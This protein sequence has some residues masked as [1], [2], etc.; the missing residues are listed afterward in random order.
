[1]DLEPKKNA[2]IR[3][4]KAA[5]WYTISNFISKCMLYLFTPL[6]TRV[7]T[8]VQYGQ[9]NNYLSWQS[10]L[11][12]LLA[13]DMA[14]TVAVAYVDHKD[15]KTFHCYISTVTFL[16]LTIPAA[17]GAAMLIFYRQF[18][19]LLGM[20]PIYLVLM[21]INICTTSA[22]QIFQAEQRSK[23]QYKLS[24]ALTLGNSFGNML[25]TLLLV[26]LLPNKLF[27]VVLGSIAV[28]TVINVAICVY[29]F[30][31]DFSIKT[32]YI[33][34]A[35]R[36][37]LPL[38]PHVVSASLLSS[39]NKI[40]ITKLC[41][42]A[43]TAFY[44]V[45]NTCAMV[46][47]LFVTSVNSAWVPWFFGQVERQDYKSIRKVTKVTIPLIALIALAVCLVG[48]EVVLVLGGRNYAAAV[49]MLPPMIFGCVVRY[50]YTL[51]V[52]I[53]F[54]NKKTGGISVATAIAAVVNVGLNYVMIQKFGYQ[55]AAYTTLISDFLLLAIHMYIVKR[56]GMWHIFD[57]KQ[58][59]L[60][61]AAAGVL[62]MLILPLYPL[63]MVRYGIIALSVIAAV[64]A[65]VK[66]KKQLKALLKKLKERK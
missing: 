50:V 17:F 7:L 16:S 47:I 49:Y 64:I 27:G 29:V 51:Y 63:T 10:I 52:N 13:W 41:G 66:F 61:L 8:E 40:L 20:E 9:Y 14:S 36:L 43:D 19:A 23:V 1:M 4:I 53:E 3:T 48:P 56:Q 21:I 57:N 65:V 26:W 18:A 5:T 45:V 60:L 46:V 42:N 34:Y 12:A 6:Y 62:C 59:V 58:N 38:I 15:P 25:L 33:R 55:A 39:A 2:N 54:Y 37:A 32:D 44:S 11:V 28:T 22:L 24:S 35:L 31:R 30:T